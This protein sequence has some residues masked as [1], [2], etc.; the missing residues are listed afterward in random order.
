MKVPSAKLPMHDRLPVLV[1]STKSDFVGVAAPAQ[2]QL[3]GCWGP[4]TFFQVAVTG[5]NL[6]PSLNT[7][8]LHDSTDVH[9]VKCIIIGVLY[10]Q[11]VI[12]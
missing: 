7:V 9:S 5:C 4:G 12:S 11:L 3:I 10:M 1:C 6:I 8:S 2:I